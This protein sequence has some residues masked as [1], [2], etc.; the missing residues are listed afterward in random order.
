[1]DN[2]TAFEAVYVGSIPAE[3]TKKEIASFGSPPRFARR[4]VC[5]G[6]SG[7]KRIGGFV[8]GKEKFLNKEFMKVDHVIDIGSSNEDSYLIKDNLFAVFDGFNSLDS[9]KNENGT[10]GGLIAATIARDIFSRNQGSLKS[11][12]IEANRKIREKMLNSKIDTKNKNSLWG[13]IFAAVRIKNNSFEWAQL[14]DC[15]IVIVF[16]DKSYKLLVEDFDHGG[17]VLTIWKKLAAQKKEKIRELIAEPLAKLRART[18]ETYGVLN[19]EESVEGFL[20][21]GEERLENISNILLFTDG[22]IIPKE[23]PLGKDDWKLFV[24]LFIRGGLENIKNFVRNL[25][26]DDP[27]CWKYP[28]YKQH[29]DITA[30]SLTF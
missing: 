9:F 6:F 16:K 4:P 3:G 12:A 7:Q 21:T 10:T 25:Q 5:I 17:E 26:K 14:A 18:N 2:T 28:R 23:D 20:K 22:L 11:L 15:L 27:K 8:W 19:G 24:D 13:T 1:M 30:I 29:D